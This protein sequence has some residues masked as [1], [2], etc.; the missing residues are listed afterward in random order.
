M[1][2]K[3]S[4]QQLLLEEIRALRKDLRALATRDDIKR[5]LQQISRLLDLLDII[6][7]RHKVLEKK[8]NAIE[9]YFDP[10]PHN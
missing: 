7:K 4:E 9:D 2:K 5:L 1:T 10:N 3:K 8:L 6:T